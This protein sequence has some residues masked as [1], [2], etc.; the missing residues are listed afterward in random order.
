MHQLALLLMLA[1]Q[2][3]I[4]ILQLMLRRLLTTHDVEIIEYMPMQI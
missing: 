1:A 4:Q 2:Q 3:T